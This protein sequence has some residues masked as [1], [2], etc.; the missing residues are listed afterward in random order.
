MIKFDF[1]YLAMGQN[2]KRLANSEDPD[3]NAPQEHSDLD[4]HCLLE[5]FCPNIYRL[6]GTKVL[7]PRDSQHLKYT[8]GIIIV[9]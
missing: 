4:Q 1:Y 8:T 9:V 7:E 6:L 3:Q 5:H 2:C